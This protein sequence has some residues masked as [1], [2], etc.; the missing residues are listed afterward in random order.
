ML[1][2][3]FVK[4]TVNFTVHIKYQN[5]EEK[6]S[7]RYFLNLV[8]NYSTVILLTKYYQNVQSLITN[9]LY[10]LKGNIQNVSIL[11]KFF[12]FKSSSFPNM[13]YKILSQIN[14]VF[15]ETN[16]AKLF[17]SSSKQLYI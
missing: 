14:S 7:I 3:R 8:L 4:K 13:Q 5:M 9:N 15:K 17:F 11:F 16:V 1:A 6:I 2:L 10:V 12:F